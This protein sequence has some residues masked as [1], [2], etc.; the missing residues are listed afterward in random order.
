MTLRR[1]KL[2]IRERRSGETQYLGT[3][4]VNPQTNQIVESQYEKVRVPASV[5]MVRGKPVIS[6]R[7][8]IGALE[9]IVTLC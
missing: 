1:Y 8:E 4:I 5:D 6:I 2:E 9:P 3:I 7:D